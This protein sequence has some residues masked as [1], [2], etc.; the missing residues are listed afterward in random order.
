MTYL[1]THDNNVSIGCTGTSSIDIDN[2]VTPRDEHSGIRTFESFQATEGVVGHTDLPGNVRQET[3][4][5]VLFSKGTPADDGGHRLV[6]R[7]DWSID[8]AVESTAI[9]NDDLVIV[10]GFD[11]A[12]ERAGVVAVPAFR[13]DFRSRV[14]ALPVVVAVNWSLQALEGDLGKGFGGRHD[15]SGVKVAGEPTRFGLF[16]RASSLKTQWGRV[17]RL[18]TAERVWSSSKIRDDGPMKPIL[19][20]RLNM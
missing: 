1:S 14:E 13:Q 17:C 7:V 11:G 10:S 12:G 20:L 18:Y 8:V 5:V 6:V 19:Y 16:V 4:T 3:E 2:G 9:T 15:R